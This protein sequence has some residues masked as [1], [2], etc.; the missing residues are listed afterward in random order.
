MLF[1][2]QSIVAS[3]DGFEVDENFSVINSQSFTGG[4]KLVGLVTLCSV[5]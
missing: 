5:L 3:E 2:I 4:I 1:N